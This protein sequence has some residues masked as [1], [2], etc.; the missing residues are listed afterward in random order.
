MVELEFS[1][2]ADCLSRSSRAHPCPAVKSWT[3]M[4]RRGIHA[5]SRRLLA[6]T[7]EVASLRSARGLRYETG[8]PYD[9]LMPSK[10]LL[11]LLIC[12]VTHSV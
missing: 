4:L 5:T 10:C 6:L 9:A 8:W 12:P 2:K 1:N 3:G 7:V 11:H